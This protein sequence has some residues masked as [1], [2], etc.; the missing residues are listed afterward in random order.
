[1]LQ[2]T[3]C[4]L[5][6]RLGQVKN[7]PSSTVLLTKMMP[8]FSLQARRGR[9][10]IP[11]KLDI[12]SAARGDWSPPE[13]VAWTFLNP[14][15]AC[16]SLDNLETLISSHSLDI[17]WPLFRCGPYPAPGSN[18]RVRVIDR[19]VHRVGSPGGELVP[20]FQAVALTDWKHFLP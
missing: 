3:N 8:F 7:C 13:R 1:M 20:V 15:L 14:G 4:R 16:D 2:L 11:S 5:L 6:R 18:Q 10:D 17:E 19:S 12:S 9:G